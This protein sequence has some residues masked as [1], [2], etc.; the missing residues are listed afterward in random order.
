M[1]MNEQ[2]KRK[3]FVQHRLEENCLLSVKNVCKCYLN[4]KKETKT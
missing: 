2:N 3:K 4:T 1:F